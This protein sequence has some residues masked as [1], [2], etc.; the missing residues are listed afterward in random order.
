MGLNNGPPQRSTPGPSVNGGFIDIDSEALIQFQRD[1]LN[2]PQSRSSSA[3]CRRPSIVYHPRDIQKAP[4][5]RDRHGF[6]PDSIFYQDESP[7]SL[8]VTPPSQRLGKSRNS[9]FDSATAISGPV[10]LKSLGNNSQKPSRNGIFSASTNNLL[11][12][13]PPLNNSPSEHDSPQSVR[14]SSEP[15]IVIGDGGVA[16][17]VGDPCAPHHNRMTVIDLFKANPSLSSPNLLVYPQGASEVS[18][19]L[20]PASQLSLFFLPIRKNFLGEGR[21]AEVFRATYTTPDCPEPTICAVKRVLSNSEAQSLGIAEAFILNHLAPERHP[22]IIR[23]IGVK[24]E[25]DEDS[26][27]TSAN[28]VFHK[29]V[30]EGKGETSTVGEVVTSAAAKI[31]VDSA[32]RSSITSKHYISNPSPRLLLVLEYCPQGSLWDWLQHHHHLVGRRLWTR[33]ARELA[34][35]LAYIHGKGVVHHDLKPH[36]IMLDDTLTTKISDFGTA[37]V[38]SPTQPLWNGLGRGTPAYSPPELISPTAMYGFPVDVFSL[39]VTL[40][41]VGF[42]AQE[43]FRSVRNPV[44]LL[45]LVRKAG[46]LKWEE[47][48]RQHA[49]ESVPVSP[50]SPLPSPLNPSLNSPSFPVGLELFS[51]Q[52]SINTSASHSTGQLDSNFHPSIR[53]LNGEPVQSEIIDLLTRC[54]SKDPDKRPTSIELRDML[55]EL[56]GGGDPGLGGGGG[57]EGSWSSV[58]SVGASM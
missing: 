10:G 33:W 18:P 51:S 21:N 4:P 26:H 32:T 34:G 49:L 15:G 53:F 30:V 31:N 6:T 57:F 40:Y 52:N 24:D 2:A 41:V 14:R 20:T 45:V 29:D 3:G 56:D 7:P 23:L 39:A 58:A 16:R 35:A 5:K 1:P 55:S 12:P 17:S 48:Q 42:T 44:E 22:N 25:A 11:T 8:S 38:T 54:L 50:V 36:N 28:A 47:L 27:I 19:L 46:F 37:A 9:I 13:P 43:P